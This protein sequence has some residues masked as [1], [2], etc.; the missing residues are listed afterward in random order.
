MDAGQITAGRQL[1]V[2]NCSACHA[3]DANSNSPNSEAPPLKSALWRFNEDTL[4]THLIEAIR[5]G[6]DDMPIFDFDVIGADALI[7]YLKSIRSA[8]DERDD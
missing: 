1:A 6:H 3:L 4:A 8:D 7:A 2:R 5:V